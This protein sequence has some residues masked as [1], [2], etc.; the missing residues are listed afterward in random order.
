MVVRKA[1]EHAAKPVA[2]G[3]AQ[4]AEELV[5]HRPHVGLRG[6]VA[7]LAGRGQVDGAGA[8]ICRVGL[9]GDEAVALEFV[10]QA[11][12]ARLVVAGGDTR[13]V[14]GPLTAP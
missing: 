8:A 9:A 13:P 7:L 1:S 14:V 10:E 5:L 4:V 6:G 11:D 2:L 12:E 3:G